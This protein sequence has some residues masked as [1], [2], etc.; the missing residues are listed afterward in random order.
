MLRAVVYDANA[1]SSVLPLVGNLFDLD[2]SN[3]LQATLGMAKKYGEMNLK[4]LVD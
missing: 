2:L 1:V 4:A 3:G